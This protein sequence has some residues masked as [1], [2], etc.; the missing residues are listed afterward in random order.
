MRRLVCSKVCSKVH[1]VKYVVKQE[2]EAQKE[3]T[4]RLL[5]E[6]GMQ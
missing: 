6:R 2:I 5:V 4:S 1:A 3:E